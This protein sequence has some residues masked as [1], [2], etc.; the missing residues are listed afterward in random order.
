MSTMTLSTKITK[1]LVLT[2]FDK[3]HYANHFS[4]AVAV[5]TNFTNLMQLII[6]QHTFN[7]QITDVIE[8][9][10]NGLITM[11]KQTGFVS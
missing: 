2:A 3:S 10:I 6:I 7:I 9:K 5:Q 11:M 1:S 4:K 8:G